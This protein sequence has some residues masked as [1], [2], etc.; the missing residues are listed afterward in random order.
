MHVVQKD[1]QQLTDRNLQREQDLRKLRELI[2]MAYAM[3]ATKD[4]KKGGG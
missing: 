3:V 1:L 4:S 2:Q